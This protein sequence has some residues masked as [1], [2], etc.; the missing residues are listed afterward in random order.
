MKIAWLVTDVTRP[1]PLTEQNELFWE[2][3]LSFFWPI[4]AVVVVGKPLRDVGTPS[5][6]LISLLR[7][8][9]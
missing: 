3:F 4:Q 6:S 9:Y 5:Q 1:G 7:D 8:L 2:W